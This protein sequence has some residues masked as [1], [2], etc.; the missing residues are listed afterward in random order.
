MRI[1]NHEQGTA[2][3]RGW[4]KDGI[5]GADSSAVMGKSPYK[6]TLDLYKEKTSDIDAPEDENK[7]YIF[8]RGHQTE[9]RIRGEIFALT[10]K[11]MEPLCIED[12]EFPFLRASLDGYESSLGLLEAKLVGKDALAQISKGIIPPSHFIQCQHS[13]RV[14]KI[15]VTRY[16]AHD[17]GK[18]GVIQEIKADKEFQKILLEAEI[19]FWERVKSKN[20]PPLSDKDFLEVDDK[21]AFEKLISL[22][23]IANKAQEDYETA[24]AKIQGEYTHPKVS[25]LGVKMIT[26]VRA[27]NINYKSI[28]EIKELAEEY[29]DKFRAKSSVYKKI[30]FPGEK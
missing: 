29:L 28:P 22:K 4:R 1:V 25:C 27:G 21:E 17:L 10:G 13:M 14:G 18:N 2:L 5:G 12:E 26:V 8:S 7:E 3:W 16:F 6:T 30:T 20:P 9:E 19:N 23:T 15:D 24:L 11:F